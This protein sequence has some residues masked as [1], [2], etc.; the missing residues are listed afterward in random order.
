MP[1][2]PR[3]LLRPTKT[4]LEQEDMYHTN[5]ELLKDGAKKRREYVRKNLAAT[6]HAATGTLIVFVFGIAALGL[7][8]LS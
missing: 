7:F 1:I 2:T 4:D 3:E 5:K 6:I 8:S